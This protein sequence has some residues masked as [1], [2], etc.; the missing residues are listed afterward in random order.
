[1]AKKVR[2]LLAMILCFW[3]LVVTSCGSP[4][5]TTTLPPSSTSSQP[6]SSPTSASPVSP[7]IS[8]DTVK[9]TLKKL[10]GTTMEKTTRRPQYGGTLRIL[11]NLPSKSFDPFLTAQYFNG[12]RYFTNEAL[13]YG[14]WYRS[15]A[16]TGEADFLYGFGGRTKLLAGAIAESWELPGNQKMVFHVRKGV[17]WWNKPP[18]NGREITAED[19][20]WTMNR[21]FTMPKTYFASY[22]NNKQNPTA[23]KVLDKYTVELTFPPNLPLGQIL[24]EI[25]GNMPMYPPDVTQKFG[26]NTDWKNL[27]GTGP[28][29]LVDFVS[30][31]SNTYIRNPD[32]W[33][34][35]PLF[36]EDQLPYIDTVIT[37]QINDGSTRQAA[38][39][40]GKLDSLYMNSYEDYKTLKA[41]VPG[42]QSMKTLGGYHFVLSGRVDKQELPFHDLRVRQALNMAVNKQALID[43]YYSGQADML[44]F[45]IRNSPTFPYYVPLDKQPA[46]VQDLFKY[47]PEKAK[48]LLAEAGYPS[49]FKTNVVVNSTGDA[50]DLMSIIREDYLKVGV[51]MQIKPME[52]GVF[53]SVWNGRTHEQMIYGQTDPTNVYLL[54]FAQVKTQWDTSYW[55]DPRVDKAIEVVSSN[56]LQNDA[57]V[58][59][60]LRDITPFILEQA[61]GVWL[62]APYVFTTWWPWVNDFY[63]MHNVGY[64]AQGRVWTYT[65]IDQA[66]KKSVGY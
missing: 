15:P 30:D 43:S 46:S 12:Y 61:W 59:K 41:Q 29:M 16:G 49:G 23:I 21:M 35:N 2:F 52:S 51:D 14:D 28:F 4:G 64:N 26:D 48:K 22:T 19:V 13:F 40:T 17:H 37:F 25:G 66:L 31:S 32:Y 62:P 58:E 6:S 50:V 42:L 3:S 54:L 63:G 36:P 8:Q 27:T 7:V 24:I 18:T 20:A 53:T 55:Q 5:Q 1:M 10:D 44:G 65:W 11:E 38:F 34:H 60:T 57:E 45:P 33:Q 47:D 9:L 56:L 39:R